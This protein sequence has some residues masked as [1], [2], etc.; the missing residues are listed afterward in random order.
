MKKILIL[1]LVFLGSI[2]ILRPV[3]TLPVKLNSVKQ[4]DE[5]SL[6]VE[7]AGQ[8]NFIL[9]CD[10]YK[11]GDY[12]EALNKFKLLEKEYPNANTFYNIGNTYFRLGK[13]G[14]ALVYYEK[15]RKISPSD[16]D[17]NFNIKFLANMINDTDYEQT[18]ISKINISLVKLVFSISLFVFTII[19][20]IKLIIP[21]KRMFWLFTISFIFFG[22]CS[23]LFLIK[24][25]QQKQI[26]AV[27]INNAE[28][29]SGPDNSFKVNFTLPE[30]KKVMVL[31]TSDDWIEV[32]VKSMGIKGWLESKYIEIIFN[33]NII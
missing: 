9:G 20:S 2:Q 7:K 14:M 13:I 8:D 6:P 11:K 10:S 21:Q 30:G 33:G 15:A 18:L 27:V 5:T 32:G 19:I 23:A 3:Q 24:Y 4:G 12:Q 16:E 28:I 25:R 22:L 1:F 17:V 31:E 26:E 29:R